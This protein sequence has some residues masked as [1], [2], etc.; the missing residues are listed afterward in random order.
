MVEGQQA[1]PAD[2]SLKSSKN[3]SGALECMARSRLWLNCSPQGSISGSRWRNT[4]E[5]IE[6]LVPTIRREARERTSTRCCW[7]PSFTTKFNTPSQA[8]TPL[9]GAFRLV[10]KPMARPARA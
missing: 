10:C 2:F 1:N 6:S 3:C 4:L 9:A 5:Q 8:K 7:G